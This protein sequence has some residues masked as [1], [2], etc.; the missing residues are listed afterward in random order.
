MGEKEG[1][2]KEI[3]RLLKLK[4]EQAGGKEVLSR[5]LGEPP[6]QA[7]S[8]PAAP[9]RPSPEGEKA[10]PVLSAEV[11]GKVEKVLDRYGTAEILKLEGESLPLYR[12]RIPDLTDKE[13]ELLATCKKKAVEEIKVDPES[14][15]DPSERRRVFMQE[16]MKILERESKG[17]RLPP[18][19]VKELSELAFH[20]MIGYGPLDYLISDDK[21][22]DILVI[23]VN[24]PVY[25]YHS[26]YGMCSTNIVFEEEDTIRYYIDKMARLVGRRIDHQMPL[27]DARLPDG[28]R[29][30][31]TIP[32]VSLEGPT[33]SIRK[34]RKDPLTVVDL[35][36][37]GTLSPEVGALLWLLV[38]GL[39]VKPANIL[40]AGGTGSGKTT[41]LNSA[42]TFV[43]E[44]ER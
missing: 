23:G 41:L 7:P 14:I 36:N 22:E 39:D 3:E 20:D 6:K 5:L 44:H 30:N 28:S 11:K 43:P 17:M 13:R 4:E 24:K 15:A 21:L 31:A 29:I 18:A 2:R 9:K 25:V 1:K 27:L 33:L 32:P 35:M 26:R 37:F 42:T 38:H 16:L 34:F 40:F 10:G 19:R 8:P 12:L